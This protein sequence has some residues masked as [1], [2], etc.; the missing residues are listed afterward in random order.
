M[1]DKIGGDPAVVGRC[2]ADPPPQLATKVATY[3]EQLI[4]G[5]PAQGPPGD[6]HESWDAVQQQVR[7]P[8][9]TPRAAS[10][11]AH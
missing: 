7:P 9:T 2:C 6:P 11:P 3:A 1:R 8:K 10:R 5:Y 4:R